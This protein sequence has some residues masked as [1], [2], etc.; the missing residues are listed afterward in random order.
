[1]T[2][3]ELSPAATGPVVHAQT[4]ATMIELWL[5]GRPETTQ[6]AYRRDAGALL[7]H[8]GK[9][10]RSMTLGELQEFAT[11][12]VGLAPA[13]QARKLAAVKSLCA[14]AH[15]LG[16]LPFD[17]ARPLQ[18]PRLKERLAERIVTE[19]E[20]AR[21][22]DLEPNPRNHAL[23]RLTYSCGL[24]VSEVCGLR[25]ADLK[26]NKAGGQATVHG[27]GG[28]TRAVLIQ[29]K[30]WRMM[31]ALRGDAGPDDPVFRSRGRQAL[32]RSAAHRIVKIAAARA[33]LPAGVSAHWLRHAC[34]SH[35]LD[36]GAP[37]HVVQSSLGHA[38]LT[39]TSRYAH[40]RPSDS[41]S[42]Y[43]PE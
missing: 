25:W 9:P 30:L 40:A 27:K 3:L 22:I 18:L 23:L 32:D 7:A 35:A 31:G 10:L 33:G 20:A 43:L 12:L 42:L 15:R 24:R 29:A 34:A 16:Y 8:V 26:G 17:L 37:A 21:L 38:S 36:R 14:F 41:I 6:A 28:K 2:D 11:S 39:T 19:S 1:M 4:D 13:S 5:H